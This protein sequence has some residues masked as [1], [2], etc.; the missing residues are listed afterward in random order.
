MVRQVTFLIAL[1]RAVA[2]DPWSALC[3]DSITLSLDSMICMI[4]QPPF[5]L[6]FAAQI[7]QFF[8]LTNTRVRISS[9]LFNT[10]MIVETVKRECTFPEESVSFGGTRAL[11]Y[12]FECGH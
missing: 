2:S 7:F 11:R 8:F 5:V 3:G 6:L 10:E 12:P 1:C 4:S 9:E